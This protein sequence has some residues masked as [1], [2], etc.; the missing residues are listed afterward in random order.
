MN[1]RVQIQRARRQQE[2]E[3]QRRERGE[4]EREVEAAATA[5]R[6]SAELGAKS[7]FKVPHVVSTLRI[8]QI[9]FVGFVRPPCIWYP[10]SY[11]TVTL[12]IAGV[13]LP[14][15]QTSTHPQLQLRGKHLAEL[16]VST[17]ISELLIIHGFCTAIYL[18]NNLGYFSLLP[19]RPCRSQHAPS[20]PRLQPRRPRQSH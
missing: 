7:P 20:R 1:C 12:Y 5:D 13:Q 4:K 3:L 16:G 17:L 11:Y 18:S 10:T 6:I 9:H 19:S 14:F 2:L 15:S 8:W